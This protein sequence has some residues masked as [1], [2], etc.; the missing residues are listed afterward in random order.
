MKYIYF[1]SPGKALNKEIL[2]FENAMEWTWKKN[3]IGSVYG[4]LLKLF[5]RDIFFILAIHMVISSSH[6]N[7]L[8]R[9]H[10][11]CVLFLI[12]ALPYLAITDNL[13]S[14]FV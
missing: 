3:I 7:E 2:T 4:V 6:N 1:T 9:V 14:V 12:L 11:C 5:Y 10:L 13:S 8:I